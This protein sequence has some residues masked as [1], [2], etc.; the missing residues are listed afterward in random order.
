MAK[1]FRPK[2]NKNRK[3]EPSATVL[4]GHSIKAQRWRETK[5]YRGCIT[6][7]MDSFSGQPF[8]GS[9]VKL[10]TTDVFNCKC[11]IL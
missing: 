5:Y 7:L 3:K 1:R 6:N 10:V 9:S 8:A 2:Q 11:D 4:L